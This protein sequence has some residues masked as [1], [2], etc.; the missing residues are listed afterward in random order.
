MPIYFWRFR[1]TSVAGCGVV[2]GF[3]VASGSVIA[4]CA[5]AAADSDIPITD[6]KTAA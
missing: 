1:V 2:A 3:A 5:F 4:D 6:C